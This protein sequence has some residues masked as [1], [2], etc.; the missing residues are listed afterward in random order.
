MCNVI[1]WSIVVTLI[2][3]S[4]CSTEIKNGQLLYSEQE[5]GELKDFQI[6]VKHE[7][8]FFVLQT[9][10]ILS[11]KHKQLLVQHQVVVNILRFFFR[12]KWTLV[13]LRVS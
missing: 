1:K 9:V 8:I 13:E 11:V 6:D 4:I 7:V 3:Q 10:L 5:I 2:V 12:I